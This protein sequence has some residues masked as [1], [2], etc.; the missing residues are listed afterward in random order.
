MFDINEFKK[1]LKDWI[2]THPHADEADFLDYCEELIPPSQ[3]AAYRWVI[4]QSV[5]WYQNILL[6]R[7]EYETNDDNDVH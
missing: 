4:E 3:Y 1:K 7:K 5:A 6:T 2:K